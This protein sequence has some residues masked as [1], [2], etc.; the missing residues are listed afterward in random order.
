MKQVISNTPFRFKSLEDGKAFM[1]IGATIYNSEAY[2]KQ[3]SFT[4]PPYIKDEKGSRLNPD[5]LTAPFEMQVF[6]RPESQ[7]TL[8]K[9][10]PRPKKP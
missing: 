9:V 6:E 2:W 7:G 10:G 4:V 1:D 8:R 3:R 5:Y